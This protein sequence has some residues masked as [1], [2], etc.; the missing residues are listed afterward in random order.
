MTDKEIAIHAAGGYGPRK[1]QQLMFAIRRALAA[2]KFE[3]RPTDGPRA[4]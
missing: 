1:R 3:S 4:A 2:A